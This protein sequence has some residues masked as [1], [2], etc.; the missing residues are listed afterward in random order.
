MIPDI[1]I[2]SRTPLQSQLTESTFN[3]RILITKVGQISPL[4]CPSDLDTIEFTAAYSHEWVH[5]L[6]YN[7]TSYGVFLN[8]LRFSQQMTTLRWCRELSNQDL[9]ELVNRRESQGQ[10]VIVLDVNQQR[11]LFD[12]DNDEVNIFRQ[13]WYDHQW[14]NAAFDEDVAFQKAG[15]PPPQVFGEVIADVMLAIC[16]EGGFQ[17]R[18]SHEILTDAKRS[19]NWYNFSER[20]QYVK[21]DGI[22]LTSRMIME[23]AATVAEMEILRDTIWE[24]V[25]G[26]SSSEYWNKRVERL[27]EGQYGIPFRAFLSYLPV[28]SRRLSDVLSTVNT[29][30]YAALNPPLPPFV[31]EPPQGKAYAWSNVYPP[32]R[33]MK[34]SIAASRVGFLPRGATNSQIELYLRDLCSVAQVSCPLDLT[35]PKRPPSAAWGNIDFGDSSVIYSDETPAGCHDYVFWVQAQLSDRRMSLL[36]LFVSFGQCLSDY[37]VQFADYLLSGAN[38]LEEV[39]YIR[40]PLRWTMDDKVGFSCRRDFGNWLLRSVVVSEALFETMVGNG[41]YDFS[42]LPAEVAQSEVFCSTI[43]KSVRHQ[44]LKVRN[45]TE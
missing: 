41:D 32:V 33:F 16:S 29:V 21:I 9:R 6:Q 26:N 24:A 1:A 28:S 34:L 35:F 14:T 12:H 43:R 36:P 19:R 23:T 4:K 31:M 13:I 18:M 3:P 17:T 30:C 39:P 5:W 8:A 22:P 20:M 25:L 40:C 44:L 15:S 37:S 2:L 27:M 10:P 38:D 45:E 42:M 7:A 11:P